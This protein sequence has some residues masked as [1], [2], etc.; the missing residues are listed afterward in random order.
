MG[1]GAD[2]FLEAFFAEAGADGALVGAA[3]IMDMRI[4]INHMPCIQG[5]ECKRVHPYTCV[6]GAMLIG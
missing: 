4:V 3:N 1:R 2:G 6:E 5:H